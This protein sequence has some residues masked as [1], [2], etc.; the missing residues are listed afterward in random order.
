MFVSVPSDM[1]AE[2]GPGEGNP[3]AGGGREAGGHDGQ[4]QVSCIFLSSPNKL[5]TVLTTREAH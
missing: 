1:S 4:N 5:C 2:V 3:E